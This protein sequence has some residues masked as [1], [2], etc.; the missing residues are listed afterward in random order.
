MTC[1]S[2]HTGSWTLS[3]AVD[4]ALYVHGFMGQVS[5]RYLAA[6]RQQAGRITTATPLK[7]VTFESVHGSQPRRHQRAHRRCLPSE[8]PEQPVSH[9]NDRQTRPRCAYKDHAALKS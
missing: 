8:V 5:I 1:I 4:E 6:V 2:H 3:V 9:R 7:E